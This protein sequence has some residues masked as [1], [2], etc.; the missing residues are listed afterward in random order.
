MYKRQ[1]LERQVGRLQE[2]SSPQDNKKTSQCW[3]DVLAEIGELPSENVD[4]K[5]TLT[6]Y[7]QKL[8]AFDRELD[9]RASFL[10]IREGCIARR[11]RRILEKERE[12]NKKE[13]DL[14][15]QR[16]LHGRM[17]L[18][19]ESAADSSALSPGST[20]PSSASN[21]KQALEKEVR[22]ELRKQELDRQKHVLDDERKKLV[23]KERELEN[24]EHALVDADLL[25]MASGFTSSHGTEAN[26]PNGGTTTVEFSDD[27]DNFGGNSFSSF[28]AASTSLPFSLDR[29]KHG[30]DDEDQEEMPEVSSVRVGFVSSILMMMMHLV[31]KKATQE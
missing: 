3:Q 6:R 19:S 26:Q 9:E 27:D 1:E 17:K 21:R 2:A 29:T 30:S 8:R 13:R 11:E 28:G 31:R 24:R 18:P 7:E 15:H 22:L 23:A 20:D 10:R 14:E 4:E 5:L 12:L 25:N 16:C